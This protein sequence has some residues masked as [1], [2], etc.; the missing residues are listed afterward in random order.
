MIN[1][2]EELTNQDYI[3]VGKLVK[4]FGITENSFKNVGNMVDAVLNC[5]DHVTQVSAMS[6]L[7][8][9]FTTFLRDVDSFGQD[10][11]EYLDTL[12][13]SNKESE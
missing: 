9:C 12:Q 11:L 1:L 13:T 2:A 4:D 5:D 8:L 6:N 3:I 7:Y 10:I